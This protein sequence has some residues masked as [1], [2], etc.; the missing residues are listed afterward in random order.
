MVSKVTQLDLF[1]KEKEDLNKFQKAAEEK[2]VDRRLRHL[3]GKTADLEDALEDH[4]QNIEQLW[5]VISSLY[6]Q[7]TL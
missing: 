4:Q 5:G 7:K 1:M 6:Q 3:F 2:T